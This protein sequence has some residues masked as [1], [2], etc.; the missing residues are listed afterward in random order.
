MLNEAIA[1]KP[2]DRNHAAT[3]HGPKSDHSLSGAFMMLGAPMP[4]ERN[5][6]IYGETEP[7]EYF[8][9]VVTGAVRTYRVL[10]DGR[11]Q[12][13]A[14]HLPGDVFGLEAAAE[15]GDSAEAI[16]DST[17]R[18]AKRSVIVSMAAR[19]SEL[20]ADLWHWTAGGLRAAQDHMMLLGRKNAKER[21]ATFLLEIARR[22]STADLV[23]LQMCR[24]DIADYLGLTLE[25]V[26]RSFTELESNETIELSSSRRIVLRCHASL[27]RLNA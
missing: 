22:E 16:V 4:F 3:P 23:E 11:R 8:Y 15:H 19:D 7:A 26:S 20:A 14:F 2:A 24:H 17:V 12:I 25:T 21:V 6:E 18:L 27:Q 9:L 10:E 5:A 1:T 13:D